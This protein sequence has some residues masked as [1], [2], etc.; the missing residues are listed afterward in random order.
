MIISS[1][2]LADR[3]GDNFPSFC[4]GWSFFFSPPSLT[5]KKK[6][7]RSFYRAAETW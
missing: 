3:K 4:R 2:Q 7:S 5:A 6:S 1:R